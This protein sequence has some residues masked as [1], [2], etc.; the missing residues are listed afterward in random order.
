MIRTIEDRD[1]DRI[2]ALEAGA[3]GDAGLSEEFDAL[4]SRAESSPETC[5]V[6]EAGPRLA[7]YVLS[8]SYPVFRYPDLTRAERTTFD[9][10]NL[11]LHDLVIAGEF[12][13]A[14]LA[15]RLLEHLVTTA[16]A[17]RHERIS[18][19]AVSGSDG[20]WSANGFHG[21]PEVALSPSYGTDALYMSRT[22]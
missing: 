3:Y 13:G 15:R 6:V 21:H 14:G 4:R 17:L 5:F 20:F 18:L 11:H 9:S 19:I 8:L 10:P 1:W 16:T 22:I 7:G 2:V 12:R